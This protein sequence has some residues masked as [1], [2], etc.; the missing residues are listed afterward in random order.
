M[1]T[2]GVA[3]LDPVIYGRLLQALHQFSAF[4]QDNDPHGEHDCALI[5]DGEHALMFKIDYYD[6]ALEYHS[7]NPADPAVTERVITIM[8]ANEY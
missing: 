3:S 5:E 6:T 2:P 7:P 8:L 1:I 4:D